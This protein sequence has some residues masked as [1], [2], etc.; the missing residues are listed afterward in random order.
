MSERF[1]AP[2]IAPTSRRTV[3][4]AAAWT[5]P[6][7]AVA[8]A[9]PLASASTPVACP[10]V[11]QRTGIHLQIT[12]SS[13][14]KDGSCHSG[15]TVAVEVSKHD[16]GIPALAVSSDTA[17]L[18][19]VVSGLELTVTF[20]YAVKW[21]TPKA[22]SV[23]LTSTDGY[24]RTYTFTPAKSFFPTTITVGTPATNWVRAENATQGVL[25]PTFSGTAVYEAKNPFFKTDLRLTRDYPWSATRTF[26]VDLA[27]PC[28]DLNVVNTGSGVLTP[29]KRTTKSRLATT[30]A[31]VEAA[32]NG[33]DAQ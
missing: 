21:A 16:Q 4:G 18:T 13:L 2:D 31:V 23:A 30:D 28:A 29:V 9:A 19:A 10:T 32:S 5:V 24:N 27:A 1:N 11:T 14:N 7:L 12:T 33:S 6:A 22:W 17:G 20:P 25:L 26:S 8:V 15:S 3:V